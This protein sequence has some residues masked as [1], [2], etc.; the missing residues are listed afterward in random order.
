MESQAWLM[1]MT[2]SFYLWY[3]LKGYVEKD[4]GLVWNLVRTSAMLILMFLLAEDRFAIWLYEKKEGKLTSCE[5]AVHTKWIFIP[6]FRAVK[7]DIIILIFS[8]KL[9]ESRNANTLQ[10]FMQPKTDRYGI[11]SL[12]SCNQ[13]M[14]FLAVR[15][16]LHFAFFSDEKY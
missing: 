8:V 12:C 11:S 9:F 1:E 15:W 6:H 10:K 14:L 4:W 7:T 13:S 16:E 2:N 5:P 3:N